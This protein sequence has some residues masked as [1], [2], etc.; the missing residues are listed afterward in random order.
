M[1]PEHTLLALQPPDDPAILA[2]I[3]TAADLAALYVG[4]LTAARPRG[5]YFLGGY[6]AGALLAL[7][8][9]RQL[10]AQGRE[11]ALLVMLDPLFLRYSRLDQL[12]WRTLDRMVAMVAPFAG[13]R[14]IVRILSAM[15]QDRGLQQHVRILENHV[16][17]P[18]GGRI[19]L[20]EAQWSFLL[21]RPRFIAGWKRI[22][23]GGLDRRFTKG[24]H[25]SF[26][27]PPH[28]G[29][30]GRQLGAWVAQRA[31]ARDA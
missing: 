17:Q 18:F 11:V 24:T 12:F 3:G 6:S 26:M 19:T 30:L 21:R 1:G 13:G 9:A 7:E 28:V 29:A 5:P 22:A 15:M 2:R 14:R 10:Q 16:P 31:G 23:G 20:I 8:M 4:K 25:H 27:R